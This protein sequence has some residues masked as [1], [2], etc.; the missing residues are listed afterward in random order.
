MTSYTAPLADMRFVLDHVGG[1]GAITALPGLGEVTPDVVDAVLEEAAKLAANVL[2]PL[3][4]SGDQAGAVLQN[5]VVR[6]APGFCEAY[7]EYAAGGWMGLVFP[8]AF[9]G[10]DLPWLVN[11]A[12]V[13][14]W[15]AANLSFQLCPLLTQGAIEAILHH[16]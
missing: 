7:R 16:G 2:A 10:Q 8:A 4:Q 14:I 15:N 9:G 6:T 11:A 1:L 13:E 3:N 12:V 5:G